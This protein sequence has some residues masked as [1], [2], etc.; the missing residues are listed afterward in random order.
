MRSRRSC[1]FGFSAMPAFSVLHKGFVRGVCSIFEQPR[2]YSKDGRRRAGGVHEGGREG[3]FPDR[4]ESREG[5]GMES[6]SRRAGLLISEQV[7]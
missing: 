1:L 6:M 7:R 5:F 4:L 2:W 3:L